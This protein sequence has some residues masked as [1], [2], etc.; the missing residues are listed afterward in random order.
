MSDSDPLSLL[1]CFS[2]IVDPRIE[3]RKL[4]QLE[5]VLVVTACGVLAGVDNLVELERFANA[6]LDWFREFLV[7]ENG[8]PSHDT[9]GRI[10]SL[11]DPAVVQRSFLR[12]V[13]SFRHRDDVEIIAIDGKTSRGSASPSSGKVGLHTLS[14]WATEAGLVLA[15]RSVDGKSN[16][17]NE[18]PRLLNQLRL[19]GCIV[20]IDAMGC[21]KEIAST[22]VDG[23]GDYVLQVKANHP[24][25]SADI[26]RTFVPQGDHPG[27]PPVIETFESVEK[28]HGRIETRKIEVTADLHRIDHRRDWK[29]LGGVARVTRT[30]ELTGGT[31]TNET[32]HYIFSGELL[33]S[34][35]LLAYAIRQHWG[36]EN[37]LHW[38]LD[39]AFR[40]DACQVR[41]D[42]IAKTSL[43]TPKMPQTSDGTPRMS[44]PTQTM[45]PQTPTTLARTSPQT[46][47]TPALI[48]TTSEQRTPTQRRTSARRVQLGPSM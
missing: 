38:V 31:T 23:G 10:L 5:E 12:W 19:S 18:I 15:Q 11:L 3:R 17:I 44:P 20:T 9:F 40:E 35:Q 21:Q 45:S 33:A 30:R 29:G 25:L 6:R 48:L 26:E 28:G 7:L 37:G 27:S 43:R 14:A 36:I 4:H 34:L 39:V 2:I 22:I 1:Q 8:I 47:R 13:Q 24:T 41:N 16:E 32:S 42:T 46:R